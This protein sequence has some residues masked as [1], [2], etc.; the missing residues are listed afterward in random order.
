MSRGL[1]E[2]I[3]SMKIRGIRGFEPIVSKSKKWINW[4]THIGPRTCRFC[5][6]QDGKIFDIKFPPDNIPVHENCGCETEALDAIKCG[7]ATID[8][9]RGADLWLYLYKKLPDNY[10]KKEDAA[11]KGWVQIKGN[12]RKVIPGATIGG[13]V[14]KNREGKLPKALG[15]IWYEAD[16]NYMGGYRGKHRIL[17]SNDG[18]MFVTYDH[19]NTFYELI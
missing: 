12:L 1:S 6:D 14:Y 17:Y 4:V 15:R 7:T 5:I 8:R 10:V 11:K 13:E 19:N 18:L 2:A 3:L 16:I 9:G